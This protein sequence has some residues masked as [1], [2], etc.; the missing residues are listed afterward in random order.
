[1]LSVL[2]DNRVGYHEF[3]YF[4][5]RIGPKAARIGIV[6][7]T[8]DDRVLVGILLVEQV[9]ESSEAN[10]VDLHLEFAPGY[11]QLPT[12]VTNCHFLGDIGFEYDQ[13]IFHN[14]RD[15]APFRVG[16][17]REPLPGTSG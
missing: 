1:M 8:A 15:E 9:T 14:R 5:G 10:R 16:V 11:S 7:L 2:P 6:F 12:L 13:R 17:Q 4:G 3:H